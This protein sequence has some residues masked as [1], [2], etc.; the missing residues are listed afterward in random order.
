MNDKQLRQDV[1]DALEWEPSISAAY[2]GVA[3]ENGVVTLSG[4]VSTYA[5]KV[6]AE[7]VTERVD[8]VRGIAQEIEVRDSC[9]RGNSDDEVARRALAAIDWDSWLP[10]ET[11]R[12]R[13]EDGHVTLSGSVE[14][15]YQRTGAE[16]DVRRLRG[17][18]G[19]TNLISINPRA[20]AA[21]FGR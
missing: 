1:I 10:K 21:D 12:V 3:V 20:H 7:R 13:V 6:V 9:A 15:E 4:H 11:V 17:V 18:L 2:I 8:G 14:W 5:E 19:L 16:E